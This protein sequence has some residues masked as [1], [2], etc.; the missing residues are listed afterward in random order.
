MLLTPALFVNHSCLVEWFE[1]DCNDKSYVVLY[2]LIL[3]LNS[4]RFKW[5]IRSTIDPRFWT[6]FLK[7]P[8]TIQHLCLTIQLQW[9]SCSSCALKPHE[10]GRCRDAWTS[11]CSQDMDRGTAGSAAPGDKLPLEGLSLIHI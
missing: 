8:K 9:V 1:L 11:F 3:S 10:A 5:L 4:R 7:V 2:N 6:D